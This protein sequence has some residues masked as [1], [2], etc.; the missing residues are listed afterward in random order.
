MFNKEVI[1]KDDKPGEAFV[2]LCEDP[3]AKETLGWSPKR[4]I[5]DYIKEYLCKK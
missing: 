1:Y 2:T 3:L 4:N 5:E